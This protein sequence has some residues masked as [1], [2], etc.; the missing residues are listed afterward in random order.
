MEKS[1]KFGRYGAFNG[2]LRKGLMTQSRKGV[3]PL[4]LLANPTVLIIAVVVLLVLVATFFGVAF[5]IKLNILTILGA[6]LVI[7]FGLSLS[8][9]MVNNI[10][11]G[12]FTTGIV[13]VLLPFIFDLT[14][15]QLSVL[16]GD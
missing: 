4:A 15:L 5:F 11:L 8:K 1:A 16:V 9:G 3:L 14:S 7:I 12:L 13:L 10:T 6:F 2:I